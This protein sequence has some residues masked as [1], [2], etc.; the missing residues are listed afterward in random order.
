MVDGTP[1]IHAYTGDPDHH[2][3]QMPSIAWPRPTLAQPSR[4]RRAELQQPTPHRFIGDVEPA[5]GEQF[6]H[7]AVAQRKAEIQPN[8]VLDDFG[9][10]AIAAMALS[11][12]RKKNAGSPISPHFSGDGGG[13]A[14]RVHR[15][16]PKGPVRS[17]RGEMTLNVEGILNGGM[18]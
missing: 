13:S 14:P 18:R 2:L 11:R 3:V 9:R 12:C 1:K 6:F 17:C 5:L 10:K 4:N 7:V 8:R 16:S 15:R